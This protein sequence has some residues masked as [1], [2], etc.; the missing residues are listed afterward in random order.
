MATWVKL[1]DRRQPKAPPILLVNTHFDHLGPRARLESA[2]LLRK[3]LPKLGKDCSLILT[4][5]FN[6]SEGSPP[7]K[8]LFDALDDQPSP[9]I[10]SYR[11][12]HRE[13]Q[14]EEGTANGFLAKNT[15][16][17]RIDWIGCSRDWQV[18]AAA[19]DRAQ[20]DGRT[21]SDHFP[22][23]AVLRRQ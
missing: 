18:Q 14:P 3:R 8:A 23:T 9:V 6:A 17:G 5:D 13:R 16:G 1:V 15:Q 11:A 7:Y 21:P 2:H 20:R 22:I 19:I 4:G 12:V 10:D